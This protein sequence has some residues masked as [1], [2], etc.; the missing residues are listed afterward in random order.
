MQMCKYATN[1]ATSLQVLW[2]H[3]FAGVKQSFIEIFKTRC[4]RTR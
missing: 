4:S 3:D 2:L 1:L